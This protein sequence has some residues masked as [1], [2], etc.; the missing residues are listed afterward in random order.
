MKGIYIWEDYFRSD[1][2]RCARLVEVDHTF[3]MSTD[4]EEVNIHGLVKETKKARCSKKAYKEG[5]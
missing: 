5:M 1:I 2:T 4:G 3:T